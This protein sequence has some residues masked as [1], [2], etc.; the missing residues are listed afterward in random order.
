MEVLVATETILLVLLLLLVAGLLRSHAEILRR[1]GPEEASDAQFS[2]PD[3]DAAPAYVAPASHLTGTTLDGDAVQIALG[4]GSPPTLIAFLTS[5]CSVCHNFWGPLREGLPAELEPDPPR[6]VVVTKD[7]NRESP[8]KLDELRPAEAPLIMSSD[9]WADYHVPASPYFVYLEEGVRHGEGSA[10]SWSQIAS[11]LR[12]AA[13]DARR[14][15]D[16]DK[17]TD[18]VD[19]VLQAAGIGPEHPSLYPA[20]PGTGPEEQ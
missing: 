12:D 5:G 13:R 8:T 15:G 6:L 10:S 4:P 7:S 1:L 14:A 20:P 11:L 3:P 17:R 19:E 9:A 2:L 18:R 16:G